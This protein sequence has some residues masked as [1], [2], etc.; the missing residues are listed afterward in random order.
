MVQLLILGL[1]AGSLTGILWSIALYM[2][3]KD[4][5]SKKVFK[6]LCNICHVNTGVHELVINKSISHMRHIERYCESCVNKDK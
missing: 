6:R 2:D 5:R 4:R 3:S 1:I